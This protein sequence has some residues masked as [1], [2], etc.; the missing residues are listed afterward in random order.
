MYKMSHFLESSN[1]HPK[2]WNF[3]KIINSASEAPQKHQL[4]LVI[5]TVPCTGH[6]QGLNH[7]K[8]Q[9]L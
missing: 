4:G 3:V 7:L 1:L 6:P 9:F 8:S 2:W 5:C